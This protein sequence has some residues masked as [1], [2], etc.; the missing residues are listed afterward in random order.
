MTIT[1][2][3]IVGLGGLG[4]LSGAWVTTLLLGKASASLRHLVWT[5]AFAALVAIPRSGGVWIPGR[6]CNS[7][8]V[9]Q[10]INR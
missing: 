10:G 7:G 8:T 9:D 3:W 4:I 1:M 6:G 5:A 2:M